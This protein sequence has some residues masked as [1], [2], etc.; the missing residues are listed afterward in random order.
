VSWVKGSRAVPQRGALLLGRLLA[1]LG[2]VVVVLFLDMRVDV[3]LHVLDVVVIGRGERHW[4]HGGHDAPAV[5][6]RDLVVG[7]DAA[8]SRCSESGGDRDV[9]EASCLNQKAL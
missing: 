1:L 6:A 5:L 8:G 3:D 9:S 2:V 7:R 4:V